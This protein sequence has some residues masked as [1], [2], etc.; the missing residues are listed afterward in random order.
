M[1][2]E[3]AFCTF[4]V[5]VRLDVGLPLE[6]NVNLE[7][8]RGGEWIGLPVVAHRRSRSMMDQQIF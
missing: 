8:D 4:E 3:C 7:A 6:S 2:G 1:F 5:S